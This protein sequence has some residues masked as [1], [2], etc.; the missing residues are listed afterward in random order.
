MY[1]YLF[2]I[3][4]FPSALL[5]Q[6]QTPLAWANFIPEI[7]FISTEKPKTAASEKLDG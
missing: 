3:P 5:D 1:R 2:N 4:Y 7:A 6:K